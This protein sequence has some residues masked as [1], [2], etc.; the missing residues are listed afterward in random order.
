LRPLLPPL[1]IEDNRNRHARDQDRYQADGSDSAQQP[2]SHRVFSR[3]D[4]IFA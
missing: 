3:R 2:S 4:G 1:A